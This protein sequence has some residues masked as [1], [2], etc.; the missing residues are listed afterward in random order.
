MAKS[1]CFR[2]RRAAA[3]A[4]LALA[5]G[6][7]GT[8]AF[9]A[10]RPAASPSSI[11]L[12]AGSLSVALR[13]LAERT[14]SEIVSLDPAVA[15]VR[16]E[17]CE[18]GADPA[19]AL[20]HLLKGT[21]YRAVRI[22]AR[23]FRIERAAPARAPRRPLPTATLPHPAAVS[24]PPIVVVGDKFPTPLMLYPGS[25]ARMPA[26]ET[27]RLGE[28]S[29]LDSMARAQ[30]ILQTTAF[31]EGRNKIF[32]RGIA[33][34]SFNSWTQ[35]TT[36]IYFGDTL[37][38]FGS[39]TPN[40]KL[41]DIASVEVLEGP[42]GTLYGSGSIGGV[43]RIMPNPVDLDRYAGAVTAGASISPDASAG[44]DG[45]AMLNLPLLRSEAGV[46]LVAYRERDGGY[47]DVPGLGHN[48]NVVDIAGG[49][50]A[51]AARLGAGLRFEASGLYQRTDAR[52][53]PYA[54][55][56][57]P[58]SH[59]AAIMQPYSS[60][61]GLGRLYVEYSA[62]N[63]M[64]LTSTASLG[65]RS[66]LDTFDATTPGTPRR[67]YQTQRST[68]TFSSETRLSGAL[69]RSV[70]WVLGLAYE[71]VRDGQSRSL[72]MPE[73]PPELDEL[74]N[75]TRSGSLFGQVT[76]P[77][78]G[79]I[80][81]TL[82]A[83]ATT[84]RTDSEPSRGGVSSPIKGKGTSRIDPTVALLWPVRHD[85]SLFA[86]F[87]TSYRNGG[88]SVARGVGKVSEFQADSIVMGEV[89]LRRS[90]SGPTGLS[91]SAAASYA[92]WNNVLAELVSVRGLPYTTNIGDAKIFALE[93]TGN[94]VIV[95]GLEAES[96]VFFTSNR[97]IG[98]LPAQSVGRD[99]RL[100]DTPPFSAAA[101]MRY[102]WGQGATTY[103]AGVDMRY[104][105]R[106]VLGPGALFDVSQ[107]NYAVADL[108]AGLRRGPVDFSVAVTNLLNTRAN[109][110]A[111][112][113]P[114][115]LYK[116]DQTVPVEPLTLRFGVSVAL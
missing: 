65:A 109:R 86:R 15:T 95:P 38:G 111:L 8:Q 82:G 28:P 13:R 113:N 26:D 74:T 59:S 81:A 39:P 96:S 112:G 5:C 87:Q 88:V 103:R 89:G 56:A 94:W 18:V 4:L 102:G 71:R 85:L 54:D 114:L 76:F 83:R 61:L 45:S 41:H 53:A 58:L 35:P 21:G 46:R 29:S 97:T 43:I 80:K 60:E 30:P 115:L 110:F 33:D 44:W 69:D 106:S 68:R 62:P 51:L 40:L 1:G 108:Q 24:Q 104:V 3:N 32:I 7:A 67:A 66:A 52:D 78:P 11:S 48:R 90:R 22:G 100:P 42:R 9:A 31:G 72:G 55:A 19:R 99:R 57:G 98:A 91:F 92:R 23:G 20:A 27:I 79:A 36:S 84:A 34:S 2:H 107:G 64:R 116:R 10:D 17:A 16:V 63:G 49:R 25:V 6:F 93:A 47:I 105:G 101:S 70:T 77:L 14:G 75:V 12:P 73:A 50:G 37:L